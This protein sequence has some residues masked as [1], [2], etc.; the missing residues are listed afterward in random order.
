MSGISLDSTAAFPTLPREEM[1][2]GSRL[3][4]KAEIDLAGSKARAEKVVGGP[5]DRPS[6][7]ALAL[8]SLDNIRPALHNR[9]AQEVG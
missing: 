6:S 1:V 8:F 7:G 2:E 9:R 5:A 3:A 4:F